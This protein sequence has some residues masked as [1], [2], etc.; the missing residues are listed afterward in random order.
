MKFIYGV[1]SSAVL[2]ALGSSCSDDYNPGGGTTGKINPQLD[3]DVNAITSRSTTA[4]REAAAVSVNDLKLRLTSADGSFSKEWSSISEFDNNELFKV[5]SYTLEAI[6]GNI[7]EEGFEKPYYYASTLLTVKENKVT[8]VTLSAG[9]ANTMISIATTEAFSS[10]FTNYSFEARAEGGA[11]ITYGASETRPGYLRPGKVTVTAEVTKPNGLSATLEAAVFVAEPK[12]HYTVTVDV[13]NGQAG[14]AQLVITYDDMLNQEDVYIDL[15]DEILSAP[16]PAVTP[17]GFDP[18]TAINL[19]EGIAPEAAPS[20]FINAEGKISSVTL[21]TQS[22]SL[23]EQG[24]PASIDLAGATP[25]EQSKLKSLGLNVKG[26]FGNIDQMAVVDFTGVLPHLKYVE[27]GNNESVFTITAKDKYSKVSEPVTFTVNVEPIIVGLSEDVAPEAGSTKMSV[28]LYFNGTD[29]A[30]NVKI[31]YKNIRGTW[32]DATITKVTPVSAN[33]YIVEIDG[34]P[35]DDMSVTLRAVAG[36]KA[37]EDVTLKKGGFSITAAEND[38]FATRAR[39]VPTF[40]N[41]DIAAEAASIKYE[42]SEDGATYTPLAH[43]IESD[44]SAWVTG[45]PAGKT[46]TVRAT[47]GTSKARKEITTEEAA[48][49]PNSGME[50]WYRQDGQSQYWWVDY[51]GESKEA[52]VWGTMN[53]LTTSAGGSGTNMFDHKGASYCAFS[54]TQRSNDK[55][56][57]DYSAYI[58]TVGWG[59]NAAGGAISGCKNLTPGELYLGHY[60]SANRAAS[61]DGISF[62]SRPASLSFYY[63]YTHKNAADYGYATVSVIASNGQVIATGEIN[64]YAAAEFTAVTIPLT[65]N[66]SAPKAAVIKVAFKSSNNAACQTISNDNLNKPSFGNTTDGRYTGSEMWVDDIKLNY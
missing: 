27:G 9:L 54:G 58:A 62:A 32:S 61:Y 7:E 56:S 30:N 41:D 28:N 26:L 60:D 20:F 37:S 49:L 14:D 18:A 35:A 65:Y 13:N 59:N 23:I 5:G 36:S 53:E 44:G 15:S 64:L 21:S 31:Q 24:W 11:T 33:N 10:Y 52:A 17:Q 66:A 22:T 40:Q 16:A 29:V 42:M 12:H 45:L 63:K 50:T 19:V 25:A 2:L 46:V 4:G 43:T 8:P 57:G 38:I 39:F 55:Y 34:L 6:Y 1:L 51:P 47:I 3:L 48:Q